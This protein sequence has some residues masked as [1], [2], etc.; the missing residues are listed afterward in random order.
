MAGKFRFSFGPWNIHTGA[1]PFGP[2]V[3]GCVPFSRKLALY[4]KLGFG[5]VQFHDDDAVPEMN[6]LSRAKFGA[7]LAPSGAR[8]TPT[9]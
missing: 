8:W 6:R 4:R 2:A 9:A 3:R 7:G 1:D 5:A